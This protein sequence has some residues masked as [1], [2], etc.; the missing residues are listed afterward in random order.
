MPRNPLLAFGALLLAALL[1]A[2]AF[3]LLQPLLLPGGADRAR[4]EAIVHDYILSHPE[5]LPEAMQKLQE[6]EVGKAVDAN[7][8]A[9][10]TPFAGAWAGNAQADVTL[11]AYMDYACGYC[12]ASLPAID[13]LLESDPK[14]RI[15]YRELPIL[16]PGSRTAAEWALAAAQQGKFRPF[17]AALYAESRLDEAAI[18]R[19]AAKA[20]LDVAAARTAAG[21]QAVQQEIARNIGQA[22]QLGITGTPT[23]VVGDQM[24]SGAVGYDALVAAVARAR[25]AG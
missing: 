1:G 11:V 23:W 15:V 4:T 20:G 12:R 6:R 22:G 13:K 14:V 17:H 3:A 9:I 21:S 2:A 18:Q 25:K 19:A 8:V 7:R 10:E 5:I 16:S 24:L